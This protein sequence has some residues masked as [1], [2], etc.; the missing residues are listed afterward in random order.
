MDYHLFIVGAMKLRKTR[1]VSMGYRYPP[2]GTFQSFL[3]FLLVLLL[4][5]LL[6]EEQTLFVAPPSLASALLY[7]CTFSPHL[8]TWTTDPPISHPA[9]G[10][11]HTTCIIPLQ[12]M[13]GKFFPLKLPEAA[14]DTPIPGKVVTPICQIRLVCLHPGCEATFL[15]EELM[16]SHV[17]THF[18][19]QS[20]ESLGRFENVAAAHATS[21]GDTPAAVATSNYHKQGYHVAALPW[22]PTRTIDHTLNPVSVNG[23]AER[24]PAGMICNR[25]FGRQSDLDRHMKKHQKDAGIF[26]CQLEGRRYSSYRK[27]KLRE[28]ARHPHQVSGATPVDF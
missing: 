21:G 1:T 14:P 27:D 4:L 26:H 17:K 15:L 9:C 20:P 12:L 2:P 28:H 8:Q 25:S 13:A 18:N 6:L 3:P 5:L 16:V 19:H 10:R 24:R 7:C 23:A 22:S 11:T